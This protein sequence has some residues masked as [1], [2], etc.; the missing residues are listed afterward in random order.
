MNPSVDA[1]SICSS[2][3][4]GC[5]QPAGNFSDAKCRAANWLI[6]DFICNSRFSRKI[7][8]YRKSQQPIPLHIL[9]WKC[10]ILYKFVRKSV[11]DKVLPTNNVPTSEVLRP[12]GIKIFKE[13]Y[14]SNLLYIH[15]ISHVDMSRSST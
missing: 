1:S 10:S 3:I 14:G 9:V 5:S 2:I 15:S 8:K 6:A 4:N 13:I 12:R 7:F 11:S